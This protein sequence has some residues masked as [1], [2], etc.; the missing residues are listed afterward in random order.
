MSTVTITC[1]RCQGSA[2]CEI[3]NAAAGKRQARCS[4]CGTVYQVAWKPNPEPD[5]FF[6]SVL[7]V[8]PVDVV[9]VGGG[10]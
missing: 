1:K 4:G 8:Q 5:A 2:T 10:S 6:D 9:R 7:T 3:G